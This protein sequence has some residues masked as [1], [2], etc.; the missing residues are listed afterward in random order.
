[1]ER[2]SA[3]RR[4]RSCSGV[5]QH[6]TA[7]TS[8]GW[9]A[10]RSSASSA[11]SETPA[12]AV[13]GAVPRSAAS[14]SSA[15]A[16]QSCQLVRARSSGVVPWPARRAARTGKPAPASASPSERT[17]AGVAVKPCSRRQ[18]SGR[19]PARANPSTPGEVS[20]LGEDLGL[21]VERTLLPRAFLQ[22]IHEGLQGVLLLLLQQRG[23]QVVLRLGE[24]GRVG[25]DALLQRHDHGVVAR[26]VDLGAERVLLGEREGVVPEIRGG[27]QLGYDARATLERPG[28]V[29][30]QALLRGGLLESDVLCPREQLL[31]LLLGED[32]ATRLLGVVARSLAEVRDGRDLGID[33]L[34]RLEEI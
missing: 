3:R 10:A 27:P 21:H 8:C 5:A 7:A 19:L 11:P 31:S 9:R 16:I 1:M 32:V 33:A 22:V 29:D 15:D 34:D 4:S 26:G 30:L 24:P 12:I 23:P 25:R 6:T 20:T 14:A 2:R 18:P 13:R 28:V 17:S